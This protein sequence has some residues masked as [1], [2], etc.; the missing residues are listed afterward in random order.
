VA[1][2]PTV[3]GPGSDTNVETSHVI[4]ALISKFDRAVKNNDAKVD[5]W[6]SGK[7]RREFLYSDDFV[8]GSLFLMKHYDAPEMINL[9]CG[10]DVSI[11]ELAQ[12][13]AKILKFKGKLV[14][15]ASK[16]DGTMRKL[17]DNSRIAHLG[18][19]PT[20]SLQDGIAQ[21]LRWYQANKDRR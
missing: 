12:L 3:Y 15:D 1:I 20:V 8:S 2:P 6:G 10:Y 16:P 4:S 11:K 13:I 18:W 7:P 5:V 17:M 14:F 21:T 9:G 19:K